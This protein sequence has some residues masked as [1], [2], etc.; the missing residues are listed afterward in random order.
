MNKKELE[1]KIKE[2]EAK[3]ERDMGWSGR[4]FPY[5]TESEGGQQIGYKVEARL[6]STHPKEFGGQVWDD[7]WRRIQFKEHP[8]G[9]PR[10][11]ILDHQAQQLG[12][13]SYYSAQALRW[14]FL[15]E[16]EK[17]CLGSLCWET[18]LVKHKITYKVD[19]EALEAVETLTGEELRKIR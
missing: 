10:G 8:I 19:S 16:L 7:R 14:W 18:R 4:N 3:Q 11:N 6:T 12:F 5:S 17:E 2:L 15:T 13:H 1:N 9:V